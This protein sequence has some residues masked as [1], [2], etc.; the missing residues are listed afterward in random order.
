LGFGVSWAI[1]KL[2]DAHFNRKRQS[3]IANYYY[4]NLPQLN[5]LP[6]WIKSFAYV[7]NI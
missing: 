3:R 7:I 5:T 6:K 1:G 2:L 4:N